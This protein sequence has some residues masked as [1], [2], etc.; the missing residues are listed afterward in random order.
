[1]EIDPSTT[2]Q[3]SYLFKLLILVASS[4]LLISML[5]RY[6][7]SVQRISSGS[8]VLMEKAVTGFR[9]IKANPTSQLYFVTFV[10]IP[11]PLHGFVGLECN[12]SL[13]FVLRF[14][15]RFS[16]QRRVRTCTNNNNNHNNEDQQESLKAM[17]AV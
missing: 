17:S 7:P 4:L 11:K 13:G 6:T 8:K 15:I 5:P 14:G 1:M 16:E 12:H 9:K 10:R 3:F 2:E